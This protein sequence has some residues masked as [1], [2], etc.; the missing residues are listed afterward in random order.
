MTRKKP[1]SRKGTIGKPRTAKDGTVSR[2]IGWFDSDGVR[3]WETVPGDKAAAQRRLDARLREAEEER[4]GLRVKTRAQAP[5]LAEV[6]V[7]A[8]R[9]YLPTR[10]R[11]EQRLRTLAKLA[12]WWEPALGDKPVD[13]IGTADIRAVLAKMR[14][15]GRTRATCNRAL[16]ALSVILEAA[17]EWGFITVNPCR[18]PSLRQ[19]EG[20]K[21]P[22]FLTAAEAR[23]VIELAD[24]EW[25][26][27]F[28]M[29]VYTGMRLG[30]LAALR[31][32]DVDLEGGWITVRGS[33]DDGPKSGHQRALPIHDELRPHLPEPGPADHLVFM[34]R[35]HKG[36]GK[37]DP[38]ADAIVAPGKALARALKRAGIE[39]HITFHDLRHT[40]ATLCLEAGVS[41][42]T[43]QDFMGH[44]SLTV[45]ARYAHLVADRG[46]ALS[47]L[48]LGEGDESLDLTKLLKIEAD[49]KARKVRV[50]VLTFKWDFTAKQV[51]DFLESDAPATI[52]RRLR[53]AV[54]RIG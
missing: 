38:T 26:P 18:E 34:A 10:Q 17:K 29:A 43:L 8:D 51:A 9:E 7:R 14:T 39:R 20:R 27:L 23:K 16:A 50:S 2:K 22:R 47:R 40:F 24:P 33:H 49:V 13:E 5:T 3:Q 45:T 32:R 54:A 37:V 21:V 30:E 28:A 53:E 42:R 4:V 11:P 52:L 36:T 31:W 12:N 41:L 25:R 15:A 19:R 6:A 1:V 46:A 48:S 44:S 35:P